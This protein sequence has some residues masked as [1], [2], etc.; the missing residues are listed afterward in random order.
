MTASASATSAI[1]LR[2]HS[3]ALPTSRNDTSSAARTAAAS[4]ADGNSAKSTRSKSKA[5]EGTKYY[6]RRPVRHHHSNRRNTS[7]HNRGRL[8][9]GMLRSADRAPRKSSRA[10][11]QVSKH[12]FWGAVP[13]AEEL[14]AA[15]DDR[16]PRHAPHGRRSSR[17]EP[18]KRA[19][20]PRLSRTGKLRLIHAAS[21]PFRNSSMTSCGVR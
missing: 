20:E 12:G 7:H 14:P 16:P 18:A 17:S 19:E 10:T 3:A 15:P 9:D 8:D 21:C 4:T 5:Y 13:P 11:S 2:S 6:R 1:S